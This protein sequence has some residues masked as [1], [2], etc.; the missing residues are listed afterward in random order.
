MSWAESQGANPMGRRRLRSKFIHT[1]WHQCT[2]KTGKHPEMN[3]HQFPPI[4]C[5]ALIAPMGIPFAAPKEMPHKVLLNTR[6]HSFPIPAN[7][8]PSPARTGS[9]QCPRLPL[10]LIQVFSSDNSL[11]SP[12]QAKQFRI[13]CGRFR[14]SH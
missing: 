7:K 4:G 12:D 2:A 8:A 9:H 14:L 6:L 13:N 10:P 5:L 11:R 3:H 1:P